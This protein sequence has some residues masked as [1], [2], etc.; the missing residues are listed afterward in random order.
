MEAAYICHLE[1]TTRYILSN[2]FFHLPTR[3]A[4]TIYQNSALIRAM[5]AL[6]HFNYSELSTSKKSTFAACGGFLAA[7]T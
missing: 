2:N 3:L 1:M 4:D 6:S 5:Q 7:Y